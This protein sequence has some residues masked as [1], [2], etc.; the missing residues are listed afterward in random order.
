MEL[1]QFTS[2]DAFNA[3][4]QIFLIVTVILA[5]MFAIFALTRN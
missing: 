3:P 1:I 5:P 2:S 4:F